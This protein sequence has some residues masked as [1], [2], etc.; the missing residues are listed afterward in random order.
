[1]NLAVEFMIKKL[2]NFYIQPPW[3]TYVP[4]NE[5][6]K[7]SS[8]AST[9]FNFRSD[10]DVTNV[11][12]IETFIK[13]LTQVCQN[14]ALTIATMTNRYYSETKTMKTCSFS[15]TLKCDKE[16]HSMSDDP[17]DDQDSWTVTYGSIG[18]STN[19]PEIRGHADP[20]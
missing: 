11:E 9:S 12:Q 2:K 16:Y 14:L 20:L 8:T 5:V 6:Y 7:C 19:P 4:G 18:V 1:M 15:W 10:F 17:I 3:V 13:Y